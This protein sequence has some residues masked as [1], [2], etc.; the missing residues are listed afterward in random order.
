MRAEFK[1]WYPLDLRCSGKDLIKNHLTMALFNHAAVWKGKPEMMP[2]AYFCN[3]YINVDGEKM[4]KSLGNFYT[5]DDLIANVGAD[6]T[7]FGCAL[8][9]DT[10]DDANFEFA[11]CG[12]NVLKISALLMY[13]ERLSTSLAGYRTET[14][15]TN[16]AFFDD[17]FA[18]QIN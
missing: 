15:D 2:R 17:V 16:T 1:Y 8:A 7:R 6:A 10:L 5:I 3:G 13:C 18:N 9:G 11:G 14:K 4:S 12:Q